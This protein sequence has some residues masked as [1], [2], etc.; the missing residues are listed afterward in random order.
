MPTRLTAGIAAGLVALMAG[1]MPALAAADRLARDLQIELARV[2][3]YAGPI[4]GLWGPR[5]R[6]AL[7]AFD[8]RTPGRLGLMPSERAL[9]R[10]ASAAGPVCGPTRVARAGHLEGR[11][12]INNVPRVS[13]NWSPYV[14]WGT[15]QPCYPRGGMAYDPW[16]PRPL[17]WPP[18]DALRD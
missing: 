1:A 2:G 8:S 13:F 12:V 17:G 15:Q 18:I 10:A 11:C 16:A 9:R 4:D 6:N 7:A 14:I 3:C 5:S